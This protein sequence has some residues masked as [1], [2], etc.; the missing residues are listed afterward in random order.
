MKRKT[1]VVVIG[2]GPGGATVARG[3]ARAGRKVLLLEKGKRLWW[4]GNH[5]AGMR[6]SDRMGLSFSEEGL[7]IVRAMTLGGSTLMY[8]GSATEPPEWL[9]T[10]YGIDLSTYVAQTIQELALEPLPDDV[11]GSAALRIMEAAD[12][13]GYRFEKFRKFIDPEKC[14]SHCGGTCMLGCPYKAK[15]T[16]ANYVDDMVAAGGEVI[17]G[18][19]VSEVVI[20][21]GVATGVVARTSRGP[22]E[23]EAKTV[24]LA[25]GG[26]G[27]PCILQRSG[28]HE[29]GVGMFI[30]PLVFVTGVSRHKGTSSGPPMS[31]GTYELI[32][33]GIVLSDLIDPWAMWM[34]MSGVRNPR[35]FGDIL[36][37]RRMLGLMVKIGD[38][39]K[40]F[41]TVDG[42]I[43]KPLTERDRYRIN[44][45]AA[46]SRD[47]LI[48][49]GCR[50]ESVVIGP[51][52][53]AHPGATAR[54]GD[55]VDT[56]L[57]TRI[58]GLYV[59]DASVLPEA[60][61]RPVVLTLIALGKRLVEHLT[62]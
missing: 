30:D 57:K 56:D 62:V 61:D 31:V 29:A 13:L 38:E 60:L 20:T 10:R 25:A 1:D 12:G 9:A 47:I 18:C 51:L 19:S 42:R 43:S 54:I 53:G 40:G 3:L 26:L 41:V 2:S 52:R 39:R 58:E 24:I 44:R 6:M 37:Y 22:L 17:T 36:R 28:L 50:P 55:V 14:R 7:H 8:C 11:V 46:I 4:V 32:D 15:W 34:M 59:A 5:L 45:G 49:A 48:R 23:I 21:D 33:D 27:T 16:A 35:R